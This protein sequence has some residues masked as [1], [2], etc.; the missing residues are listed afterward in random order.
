MINKK[1]ILI[2]VIFLI[3]GLAIGC[4][5]YR[6]EYEKLRSEY[7]SIQQELNSVRYELA[8]MEAKLV[9]AQNRMEYLEEEIRK[10]REELAEVQR[11]LSLYKELGIEV[12]SGIQPP[13][14][15]GLGSEVNLINNENAKNPTWLSL[16]SFLAEDETDRST[17]SFSYDC[18]CFTQDVH[19]KA[20]LAGIR[21]AWV[22]IDFEVGMG[23]A[24][25]AFKTTDKGLVFIDCT[26]AG[27]EPMFYYPFGTVTFGDVDNWDKIAYV[28][29]GK[30]LGFISVGIPYGLRYSDYEKWQN[31]VRSFEMELEAYDE[32]LGGRLFVPEAEYR[33]LMKKL[34]ELEKLGEKLGGFWSPLG[35]VKRVE[36]YW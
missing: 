3:V 22:G 6:A 8:N 4:T 23:H 36:I 10:S 5:D 2:L 9:N 11:Q 19:N 33:Y 30:P 31:D 27:F 15:K 18:G 1:I 35:T 21:T 16:L 14:I 34:E 28:E 20:E 12:Q 32:A 26:G 24:L 25:N 17:Y 7:V 13:Y 29:I